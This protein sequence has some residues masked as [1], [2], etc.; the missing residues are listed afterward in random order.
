[1]KLSLLVK[2]GG[3]L[4]EITDFLRD[5]GYVS[6][7]SRALSGPDQEHWVLEMNI[8][9]VNDICPIDVIDKIQT[10]DIVKSASIE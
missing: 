3:T 2:K 6:L 9:T 5:E 4:K 8:Y 10:L 7:K 1:M